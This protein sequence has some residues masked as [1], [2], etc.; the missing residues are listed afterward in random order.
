MEKHELRLLMKSKRDAL[1]VKTRTIKNSAISENL[2]SIFDEKLLQT[3]VVYLT[4]YQAMGSEVNLSYYIEEA[5]RRKVHVCFP[6]MT[7]MSDSTSQML[8]RFV[9]ENF[10]KQHEVPFLDR[11]L[12][13]FALDDPALD[14][15]P[16]VEPKRFDMVVVP[17]L[18]FDKHNNRLGYGGGNYD[19]FLPKLIETAVVVGVAYSE[20]ETDLIPL[21]EHDIPLPRIITG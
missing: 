10:Y 18:A 19:R 5:Y 16:I 8:M 2:I 3:P 17:L 14:C 1:D 11:P 15:F 21:E 6:C 13:S 20:Q 7:K 4:V 9:P 12:A